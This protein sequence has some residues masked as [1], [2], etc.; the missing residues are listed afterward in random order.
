MDLLDLY[1]SSRYLRII[2]SELEVTNP[3]KDTFVISFSVVSRKMGNEI[4]GDIRNSYRS[5]NMRTNEPEMNFKAKDVKALYIDEKDLSLS[6]IKNLLEGAGI[7]LDYASDYKSA[8]S[9]L[10]KTEYDLIL[11]HDAMK[12]DDDVYV[13]DKI[14]SGEVSMA[15]SHIPVIA[16]T[17]DIKFSI[18][19]SGIHKKY[20]SFL[21]NPV[22]PDELERVL[23]AHIP[24]SK[25]EVASDYGLFPGI[26]TVEDI[27]KYSEG[28]EDL[29]ESAVKI[30]KRSKVYKE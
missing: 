17:S 29:Y 27:R 15:N 20:D 23:L 13:I 9:K 24:E 28:Y 4:I 19:E 8:C 12:T 1:L 22:K 30:Y 18:T 16:V 6:Y 3:E 7:S 26:R 11:L 25:I 21:L 2:G 10:S 14:R 5:R